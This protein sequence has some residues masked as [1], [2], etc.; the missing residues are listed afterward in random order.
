VI[1]S[2][3]HRFIFVAVP[4]T[5]TH[6]VRKAL[7]PHLG[8]DDL[9]QVGLFEARRF[10]FKETAGIRHGHISTRQI[11]PILGADTFDGYFKFAFVRNPFD[12]F[13]SY[14]SFI[15]RENGAFARDPGGFMRHVVDTLRPVQHIL[16]R[17]Q[18][19]L[20]A[21][22]DKRLQVDEV[23]RHE[24]MQASFDAICARIG[25]PSAPLERANESARDDYR[26][27]YTPELI[28]RVG[29][30]YQDDLDL[31]GYRFDD[32]HQS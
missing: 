31:F 15:A 1:I 18:W 27:Y 3:K 30:Q 4:K 7:R 9:E 28:D 23:G 14:C 22:A 2:H 26:R 6:A 5:A 19:E 12:R 20:L 24:S 8:P 13:V 25:I 16:Y 29:R 11:R 32:V 17:P 21:D 10:P